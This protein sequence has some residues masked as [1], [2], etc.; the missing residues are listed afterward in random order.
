[1]GARL[2]FLDFLISDKIIYNIFFS[3]VYN[4]KNGKKIIFSRKNFKNYIP[5]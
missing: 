3:N 4:R 2:I 5:Y 1:M